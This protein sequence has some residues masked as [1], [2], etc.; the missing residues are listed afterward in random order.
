MPNSERKVLA[1][2][3]IHFHFMMCSIDCNA[4]TAQPQKIANKQNRVLTLDTFGKR[5]VLW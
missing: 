4:K 5:G 2:N 1:K 3:E